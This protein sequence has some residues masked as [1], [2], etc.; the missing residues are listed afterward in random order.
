M[1]QFIFNK[2]INS[3]YFKVYNSKESV[4]KSGNV[5]IDVLSNCSKTR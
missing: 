1:N 2:E 5:N 4:K 3:E